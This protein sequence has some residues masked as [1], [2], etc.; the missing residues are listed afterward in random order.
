MSASQE[1]TK[2]RESWSG[3]VDNSGQTA[4]KR[5]ENIGE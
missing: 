2:G 1:M 3:D 5:L 4:L